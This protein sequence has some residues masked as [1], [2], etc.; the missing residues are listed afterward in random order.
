MVGSLNP[1]T[2][3][4]PEN[5]DPKRFAE[6]S[7]LERQFTTVKD[8]S[9]VHV[10]VSM[11]NF[12]I[13]EGMESLL[14]NIPYQSLTPV[15][16]DKQPPHLGMSSNEAPPPI[17]EKKK[18]FSKVMKTVEKG[19]QS[20]ERQ[21]Q[22]VAIKANHGKH[23]DVFHVALSSLTPMGGWEECSRT[24]STPLPNGEESLCQ[25]TVPLTWVPY[26]GGANQKLRFQIYLKSGAPMLGNKLFLL[27]QLT[28]SRDD[29]P[30]Y[31]EFQMEPPAGCMTAPLSPR[32]RI[33]LTSRASLFLPTRGGWK[34]LTSPSA[35]SKCFNPSMGQVYS[36]PPFVALETST[37]STLVLPVATAVTHALVE[38]CK[39][40]VKHV[41][42][43]LHVIKRAEGAR[44]YANGMDAM[45]EL[46][47]DGWIE[48]HHLIMK[49]PPGSSR[50]VNDKTF[51]GR[52]LV[53]AHYLP[54][55]SV[56]ER[57]LC[58]GEVA[59]LNGAPAGSLKG[60][61]G[62]AFSFYPPLERGQIG[63]IRFEVHPETNLAIGMGIELDNKVVN[64]AMPGESNVLEGYLDLDALK[65]TLTRGEPINV[66][67]L[68][69]KQQEVG[70]LVVSAGFEG[71][72]A[73]KNNHAKIPSVQSPRNG[74]MDLLGLEVPQNGSSMLD[75][76][77]ENARNPDDLRERQLITLG[78]FLAPQF[79]KTHWEERMITLQQFRDRLDA[80]QRHL[81]QPVDLSLAPDKRRAPN[82]F[83]PSSSRMDPLLAGIPYNVHVQTLTLENHEYSQKQV[84]AT[85]C[86]ITCGAPADHYADFKRG[87]LRRLEDRRGRM[88]ADTQAKKSKLLSKVSDYMRSTQRKHVPLSHSSIQHSRNMVIEA[89]QKYAEFTWEVAVRRA[90][91]FSEALGIALTSYLSHVTRPDKEDE[92]VEKWRT[93][94]CLLVFEG[95]LSAAG[96][97]SGMIEDASVALE[98][99]G[100]VGVTLLP[101]DVPQVNPQ[102]P[103]I[104]IPGS[105]YLDWI[106]FENVDLTS[107]PNAPPLLVTIGIQR[108]HFVSKV[109]PKLPPV[110]SLH[111]VLF[112][113]GVDIR[114]WGANTSSQLKKDII[115]QTQNF[116]QKAIQKQQQ[117][118]QSIPSSGSLDNFDDEEIEEPSQE[119]FD[120]LTKLNHE[121]YQKMNNYA[122]AIFPLKPNVGVQ[123]SPHPILREL[124]E[125]ICGSAGKMAHPVLLHA[126]TASKHLGGSSIIFCKSGKDRTAMQ[127]TYKQSMYLSRAT[128]TSNV[129]EDA[130]VMRTQG[131]RVA[132]CE[133]NVGQA[134][135]AFNALQIKFMPE[136]LKCPLDMCAGFLKGGRIFS[137]EG[138]IES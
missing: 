66:C 47:A 46:C 96:K 19:T 110:V 38:S 83:R 30:K 71:L 87:G 33:R 24:E 14:K 17:N 99:V 95:M 5:T 128:R 117:V 77:D 81:P 137:K 20:L 36:K 45:G 118:I 121:A 120:L 52:S 40:S 12:G 70:M 119:D 135:F 51:W 65:N 82:G 89:E 123:Q 86:N 100:R 68:D 15:S 26:K 138:M 109:P 78:P 101:S 55:L 113:M 84:V 134:K 21:L 11:L 54:Y 116:K 7:M 94:G 1:A 93:K 122:H 108:D 35:E 4:E 90:N 3:T 28:L 62:L 85:H 103:R 107:N 37:E 64:L 136:V 75:N 124:W 39:R 60:G 126:A 76:T 132:V 98:M 129:L 111:P 91:C 114:Q 49:N 16:N 6:Q 112:Q 23:P 22:A 42:S 105:S 88:F 50:V 97:E 25:C 133:K 72:N 27:G 131:T 34:C 69:S 2:T 61:K 57:E 104:Q 8:P 125:E 79:L 73:D 80:Y 29:L 115:E 18:W 56:F 43:L 32:T 10:F 58:V 13:P 9:T 48:V 31:G 74:L 106:T 130:T 102:T 53:G 44:S 59:L 67:M 127:V 92:H 41:E 63:K